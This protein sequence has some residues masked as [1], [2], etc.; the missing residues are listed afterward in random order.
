MCESPKRTP[1]A[2]MERHVVKSR[3][4]RDKEQEVRLVRIDVLKK[5]CDEKY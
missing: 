1:I 4:K 2:E 5:M 3:I